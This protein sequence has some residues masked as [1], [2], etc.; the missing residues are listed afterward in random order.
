MLKLESLPLL[1]FEGPQERPVLSPEGLAAL[2]RLPG[3][4]CPVAFV[5]DGRSGKSFLASKLSGEGTFPQDDSCEAVTQGIDVAVVPNH[6][7]HY[8]VMDCEGGN[9]A[10]SKSHTIVTVVGALLATALIFVTDGKASEAAIEALAQMLEE[11]SLIKCDGTGSLH[12]QSLFFVVNQNRLRYG[13]DS[14]EKILAAD[15]DR[16]RKDLRDLISKAYPEDRRQFFT[17]PEDT[18]PDFEARWGQLHEAIREAATPLKMGRLWM[19]GMQ[20]VQML[21]NIEKMLTK[22]GKVSLPRLHRTVILDGWLKPTIG[23]VLGSRMDK[24]LESFS[25]EE[26]ATQRVGN[27]QGTCTECK[28]EA[29]G[30]LD[31]DVDDFFCEACWRKFSPK[32]LKCGFCTGF[33]P[34]PRGRVEQVTKMWHCV[35]CLMQLGVDIS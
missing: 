23:Q 27:V 13:E 31:P 24:L 7:G 11:R 4:V 22:H 26:L 1:K 2:A 12:A 30:W 28:V 29:A 3:P 20:V 19:T 25:E 6:P 18:K 21:Q 34:W 14:L 8:I 10:M 16:D 32:V 5:G 17:I 15:H 33:H 35:D 9:N